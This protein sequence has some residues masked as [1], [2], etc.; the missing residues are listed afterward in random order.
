MAIGVN[1]VLS[2]G[3][4]ALFASQANIQVTGN[5]ISNVNTPGYSRQAV[6][7]NERYSI[8]Y[9]PGQ[10][11]QG[12]DAQEIIR[13]FDAYV[14]SNYLNKL[15]S[16]QRY[17][18][19]YSQLRYVEGVF[20]EANVSGINDSL[21]A[22]FAAWNKLAQTPDQQAAREALLA[23]AGNL[24]TGLR[25][26]DQTLQVL[27]D[28][29][30]S[31]IRQEVDS[32]NQLI[33]EIAALNKEIA[34]NYQAGRNNPNSLMDERDYK[35]RQLGAIIDVSVVDKGPGQYTVNMKNGTTLVQNEVPFSLEYRGASVENNLSNTSPYKASNPDGSQK[36]AHFRGEDHLEYT[37]EMVTDYLDE[38]TSPPTQ[39]SGA[40]SIG[41]TPPA[42]FKVSVD[43]GRTWLSNDDGS[44]KLFNA[45]EESDSVRVGSLDVW[46]DAGDVNAGD[47]F[48]I[49]PKSDI[50]WI[51]P[52][53][54][55]MNI[56][57]QKYGDGSDNSLR[58]TGGTL[59]GFLEFRDYHLGE[60]R[61]RLDAFSKSLIWEVNRIHSQGAG[62]TPMTDIMGTYSVG[63][64]DK[65]M[66]SPEA[67]FTWSDRLQSGNMSFVVYNP[68][69]GAALTDYPGINVF[70]KLPNGNFDPSLHSLEDVRDAF[71]GPL[72]N[73]NGVAV[74]LDGN[75]VAPGN[76]IYLFK[77]EIVD[78]KLH[79]SSSDPDKY[80]FAFTDDSTGLGA[81]LGLNTF[82]TGDSAGNF[83]IN[84]SITGDLN[85]INAGAVNGAGEMNPGDNI[86]ASDMFA[87][88]S[89]KV[90]ISTTWNKATE[91]TL[92]SYYATLVTKVGADTSSVKF[93]A[94]TETAIA[95]ELYNRQ[96]EI[97]GVNLDEEMSNLIKFQASYKA[98]AKLITTADEML[99]TLLS[100][101]Q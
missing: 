47:R 83:G 78:G 20:N 95:L 6:I 50:Y 9:R 66:D 49:S 30:N 76:E 46:F 51:S 25:S 97:S 44:V 34:A 54:G 48:V 65:P 15:G 3:V 98:A 1:S 22:L 32:A 56:S 92:A 91:Q 10:V 68:D 39:V 99:Q 12:V 41:G 82:F 59:G 37:L 101:K 86:I 60:Y 28:Q 52:T 67:L 90:S 29:L 64:T 31:M 13:Y 93:T 16:S 45:Q 26:A 81:V 72:T 71:N 42:K 63:R 38:S 14:E 23:A 100:L 36:T 53:S 57:T 96:E 85:R 40:T 70:S 61:D 11:G 84:E 94:S 19:L 55:P 17:E 33:K 21:S 8:N 73:D 43:G 88:A 18:A 79:I 87:L 69:T 24:A 62:L 2:M 58:I 89:K 75:P 4:G 74:D 80:C 35:V 77:A 5:N 7:L 27:E